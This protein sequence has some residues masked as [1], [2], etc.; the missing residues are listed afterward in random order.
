MVWI[1]ARPGKHNGAVWLKKKQCR[2]ME[3]DIVCQHRLVKGDAAV[4]V[5]RHRCMDKVVGFGF[6]PSFCKQ[7]RFR[8]H[9]IFTQSRKRRSRQLRHVGFHNGAVEEAVPPSVKATKQFFE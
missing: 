2:G 4:L 9:V 3:N 1:L 5:K 8:W 6:S 7:E